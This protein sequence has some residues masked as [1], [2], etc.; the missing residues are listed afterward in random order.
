M[1]TVTKERFKE[2]LKS[3]SIPEDALQTLVD[4]YDPIIHVDRNAQVVYLNEAK[5]LY[6]KF[7]LSG[8]S[9]F[10][11]TELE[12]YLNEKQKN[13]SVSGNEIYEEFI[14][15]NMIEDSLGVPE[16]LAIQKRGIGF[17]RLYYAGKAVSGLRSVAQ[18]S[19]GDL[20]VPCLC[21]RGGGVV[22]EWY[23]LDGH[24][25]SDCLALRFRK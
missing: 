18:D 7:E 15:K 4:T 17:F 22:L 19:N 13:G 5:P 3:G 10:N 9:D 12:Q 11:V 25:D 16:L 2:L 21:G 6:P 23:W 14:A 1:A 20:R 8:P 24:F